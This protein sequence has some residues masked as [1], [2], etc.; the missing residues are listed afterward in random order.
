MT[1]REKIFSEKHGLYHSSHGN[2][3]V[4]SV[5][6]GGP[7]HSLL[8]DYVGTT[9]LVGRSGG[10]HVIGRVGVRGVATAPWSWGGVWGDFGGVE[11]RRPSR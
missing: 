7:T 5:K 9:R 4:I 10:H 8:L 11:R 1:K 2:R 6:V 3:G